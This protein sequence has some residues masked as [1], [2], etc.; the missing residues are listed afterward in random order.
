MRV[1]SY[2]SLDE[3][4]QAIPGFDKLCE[5]F[6]LAWIAEMEQRCVV[7][8]GYKKMNF[9]KDDFENLFVRAEIHG[10]KVLFFRDNIPFNDAE[11]VFGAISAVY[12]FEDFFG[13]YIPQLYGYQP[14]WNKTAR[15]LHVHELGER[16]IGD[17][18]HD[19]SYNEKLK[20]QLEE[21]SFGE[22]L[23]L[24]PNHVRKERYQQFA[25]LRD[26]KDVSELFD[27]Q[28]FIN[29]IVYFKTKS[30]TGSMTEKVG[31]TKE[32]MESVKVTGSTRP[33]DNI[34]AHML[35]NYKE[36]QPL[37]PFFMGINEAA[38]RLFFNEFDAE[39]KGCVPGEVPPG[40]K[41]FY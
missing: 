31:I 20:N 29:G 36:T 10:Q 39:A 23:E 7:R 5:N 13:A 17:W 32:D 14:D 38:Y 37:L 34:Y 18:T 27:K 11:H 8:M 2:Y 35:R 33:I 3:L 41:Q 21:R 15:E 19:G 6:L 25:S 24:L 4:R 40:V 9:Y 30:V 26:A 22:F 16:A 1:K 28:A 12:L